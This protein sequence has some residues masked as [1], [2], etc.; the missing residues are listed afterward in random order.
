MAKELLLILFGGFMSLLGSAVYSLLEGWNRKKEII[1]SNARERLEKLYIPLI[2]F[3]EAGQVPDDPSLERQEL[4]HIKKLI[5]KNRIYA[6]PR[7]MQMVYRMEELYFEIDRFGENQLNK[8]EKKEFDNLDWNF[9]EVISEDYHKLMNIAGL[10]KIDSSF[11]SWI[12]KIG[13]RK[14]SK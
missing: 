3:I 8:K 5:S 11:K 4:M 9:R 13:K 2:D 7:L 1:R 10:G 12:S 14:N 6:S